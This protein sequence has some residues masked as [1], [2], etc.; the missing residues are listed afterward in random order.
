MTNCP[1]CLKAGH[2]T[3]CQTCRKRLFEGKKVSQALPFSRPVYNQARLATAGKRLSIS[4]LQTK[5]PLVL[6]GDG[7]R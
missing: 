4:G 6:R 5:M 7:W 3:F 2:S 1:G